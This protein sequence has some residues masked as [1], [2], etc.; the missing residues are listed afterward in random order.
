MPTSQNPIKGVVLVT[1]AV[2]FFAVSD[3]VSKHLTMLYAVPLVMALRYGVNLILL[4][5][6]L[7]RWGGMI[8][9]QRTGLVMLRAVSLMMGSL[10]MGLALRYMPLGETVAIIY[11]SPFIVML[12]SIPLLGERATTVGWIGASLGFVG[13][14]LIIRPGAGLHGFGVALSLINAGCAATYHLLSRVLARTET[15]A[16]MLFHTAWVGLAGFSI[17]LAATGI[18]PMPQGLD[19]ALLLVLGVLATV[20]HFLFTAAYRQA[21]AALLAPMNYLH[22]VWAAILGWVVFGHSPD[23]ITL[24]GMGLVAVAGAGIALHTHFTAG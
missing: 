19:W 2:L 22:L 11:L 4:V 1:I 5:A 23:G 21:P 24:A 17:M 3:V 16:A 9:T 12:L 20:G 13:V 8:R 18:G 10:T 15:M 14:M 7:G 6:V